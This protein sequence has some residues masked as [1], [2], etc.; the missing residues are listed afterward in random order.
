MAIV[1]D[2]FLLASIHGTGLWERMRSALDRILGVIL[3][4][5]SIG[6]W[7]IALL[8]ALAKNPQRPVRAAAGNVTDGLLK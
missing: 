2:S 8:A 6:L 5:A 7:P 4:V 3:F 1:P